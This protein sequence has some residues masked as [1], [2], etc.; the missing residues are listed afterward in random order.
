MA[1][2]K[3]LPRTV[4]LG[5]K[6]TEINTVVAGEAITPGMLI[7]LADYSG[8]VKYKKHASTS[9]EGRVYALDRPESNKG[10]DDAYSSG[11]LVKAIALWPGATVWAF[12]ASG[13]NITGGNYL[14][15]AG[16][17]TLKVYSSGI[18]IAQAVEAVNNSAGPG[19]A[20]IRVEIV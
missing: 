8:T 16:N 6:G 15:S 9:K 13:Q 3:Q 11:D 1:I 4:H 20:R 10:V 2:T 7:E 14:E 19:N 12:I 17:G 5:G 18:K